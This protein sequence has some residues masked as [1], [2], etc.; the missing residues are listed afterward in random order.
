MA[1]RAGKYFKIHGW[2]SSVN[3]KVF[4]RSHVFGVFGI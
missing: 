2:L 3:E 1:K 4:R